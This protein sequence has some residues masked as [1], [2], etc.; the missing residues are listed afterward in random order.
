LPLVDRGD[1]VADFAC[2][3]DAVLEV[4]DLS[5]M[6]LFVSLFAVDYF[7]LTLLLPLMMECW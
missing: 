4:V 7:S 2:A 6:V 3:A 5:G 1:I